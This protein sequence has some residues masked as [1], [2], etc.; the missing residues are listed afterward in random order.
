[1]F[2]DNVEKYLLKTG[3]KAAQF[4]KACGLGNGSV[5]AWRE[6]KTPTLS[7]LN[8]IADATGVAAWKWVR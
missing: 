2:L 6:G 5:K 8:K 7:T 1:M 4:E 3:M